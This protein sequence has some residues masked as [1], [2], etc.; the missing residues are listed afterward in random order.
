MLPVL[1]GVTEQ[2]D[3]GEVYLTSGIVAALIRL[4]D[5]RRRQSSGSAKGA[6]GGGGSDVEDG[7]HPSHNFS[8]TLC[9]TAAAASRCHVLI[10][11]GDTW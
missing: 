2:D 7:E 3:Y 10:H 5:G 11:D 1:Q 6:G 8:Y 9:A 4:L